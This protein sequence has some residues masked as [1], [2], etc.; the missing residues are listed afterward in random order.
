MNSPVRL[1]VIGIGHLGS[2]H[3]SFISG[4]KGAVPAGIH[5][6]DPARAAEA[7]AKSNLTVF[8]SID[9]LLDESDA[10]IIA[11]PTH[12]HFEI[13]AKALEKAKHVFIEKPVTERVEEARRLRDIAGKRNLKIQVGHIERFN[14]AIVALEKFALAPRFIESHR[15]AQFKPRGTDV[16]VVLDLMIH[17]LD[18]ILSLVRSPVTNI[19]ANGVAVV[20]RHPDIANA[21]IE[22]ENGCVAN[23]TAS[24]ISQRPMR[25]MR[26]FQQDAY[27]S[28]DFASGVTEVFRIVERQE[29]APGST[30]LLGQIEQ[31]DVR[32]NIVYEQPEVPKL[33]PLQYEQQLFI[34][35]I[36]H[37]TS[38][39][40]GIDDAIQ[41]L[42]VA[43]EILQRIQ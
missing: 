40:V 16:A 32:R 26:L 36:A 10:V 17:D 13:A 43:E 33:N 6:I 12:S 4:L 39:I 2:I 20:T 14:P 18:I 35:A 11:T 25:K 22:F 8:D 34:Q 29:D 24:R 38:P 5:D 42:E 31:G 37:D 27:L 21:R 23:V 28:I 41:A 1:G 30:V 9:A 7:G 19:A 3:A 15:L